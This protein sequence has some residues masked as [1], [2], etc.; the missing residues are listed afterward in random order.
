MLT[1]FRQGRQGTFATVR[2]S[3]FGIWDSSFGIQNVSTARTNKGIYFKPNLD[4]S[5]IVNEHY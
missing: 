5:Q 3:G 4:E 1:E 2:Y